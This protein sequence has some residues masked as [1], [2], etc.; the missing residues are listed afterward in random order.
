[1]SRFKS[2]LV[3]LSAVLKRLPGHLFRRAPQ[4]APEKVLIAHHLLLGD[5]LMLTPLLAKIRQQYPHAEICML[6]QKALAS[7]YAG[8]PY[9]VNYLPYHPSETERY[10][11]LIASGPYDL[12]FVPAD[13][14][15][16]ILA[17]AMGA[18]WIKAFSGDRPAYK[19]WLVDQFYDYPDTPMH[20]ADINTLMLEGD[21]PAPFSP[22]QW[23]LPETSQAE[24]LPEIPGRFVVLHVGASSALKL[25]S[26]ALWRQLADGLTAEGF[27]VVWSGGP[28][29]EPLV[30]AIGVMPGE[31]NLA[32]KLSLAQLCRLLQQS[33]ALVCPDTGI[34][35]LGRLSD[36]PTLCLFGPG[37]P[38]VFGN[39]R[40]WNQ[41]NYRAIHKP[42][43][44]RDQHVM[45]KRE[46]PWLQRCN[47]GTDRCEKAVCMQAITLQEVQQ[48]LA[49]LLHQDHF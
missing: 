38:A 23:P 43:A 11:E 12:A 46:I 31:I 45:F 16:S 40:F 8:K 10:R 35:H 37:N 24:I 1:M 47:R 44:C 2:R 7:L 22:E 32:G 21:Y 42:V 17:Y 14:R 33:A 48:Q 39:C 36:T 18:R 20:W 27:Q 15:Y 41:D 25:W 29:E 28:G 13:N 3:T 26:P 9:G 34:S 19:S 6:G 5:T 30:E 49:S 4:K